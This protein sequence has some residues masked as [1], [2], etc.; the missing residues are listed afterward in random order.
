M[1]DSLSVEVL[2][3]A[4]YAELIGRDQLTIAVPVGSTVADVIAMIRNYP[5]GNSIP[6]EPAVACNAKLIKPGTPVQTGDLIALLPP[7]AGG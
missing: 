7:F 2:L 3:F 1:S 4:R 5:G 6:E